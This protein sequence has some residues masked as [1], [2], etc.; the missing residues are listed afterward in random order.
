M[1]GAVLLAAW[2]PLWTFIST[3]SSFDFLMTSTGRPSVG[4]FF[5]PRG[6]ADGVT[7]A[8]IVVMVWAVIARTRQVEKLKHA[9]EEQSESAAPK[10]DA[11]KAQL[12]QAEAK[13]E[14]LETL[15]SEKVAEL[16]NVRAH[17]ENVRA[18]LQEFEN[19]EAEKAER[20]ARCEE[21]LK[22]APSLLI[23]Y[24]RN[25][26]RDLLTIRNEGPTTARNIGLGQLTWTEE[27]FLQ[28]EPGRHNLYVPAKHQEVC[29]VLLHESQNSIKPLEEFVRNYGPPGGKSVTLHY[30]DESG[31]NWFSREFNLAALSDGRLAWQ[32]GPLKTREQ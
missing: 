11:V 3:L 31:H 15:N 5:L 19:L 20:N 24:S 10:I 17:L 1:A 29:Q 14:E 32:P 26:M 25:D 12:I 18:R 8:G 21:L 6:L 16:N 9:D 2:I 7:V 28:L 23:E 27:R 30:S 13:R 22:A 4:T